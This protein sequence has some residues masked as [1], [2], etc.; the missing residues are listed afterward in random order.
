ME[1]KETETLMKKRKHILALLTAIFGVCCIHAHDVEVSGE[2]TYYDDGHHSRM[3]C[4]KLAAEQA[5]V[6]ALAKEFGTLVTQDF[7]QNVRIS[8]GKETNDLLA[9]SA[10]EVKGEWIADIGEP[11]YEY[12]YDEK[13]NLIVTCKIKGKARPISNESVS[14]ETAVLKNGMLRD[15]HESASFNDGDQMYLYF[16]GA[17]DGYLMVFFEDES[18]TVYNLLPYPHDVKREVKLKKFQEYIFFSPEK[19]KGE[20][21]QEEEMILTAPDNVEYNKMYVVY[22]PKAFSPPVMKTVGLLPEIAA[23]NFSKWLIK[24]RHNDP[25]MGVKVINMAVYPRESS[26]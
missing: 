24:A 5:R 10:T 18:K 2:A 25:E 11:K 19:G 7:V 17:S 21:G 4:L 6:N 23:S 20:F 16:L 26:N 8:N 13:Q 12:A 14:F 22:S 15:R 3:E 1:F 9:L